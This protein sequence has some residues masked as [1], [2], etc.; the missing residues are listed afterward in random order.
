[1]AEQNHRIRR[2]KQY[3]LQEG[4]KLQSF[5]LEKS[6][7]IE[8]DKVEIEYTQADVVRGNHIKIGPFTI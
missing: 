8:G 5:S 2:R 3:Q 7:V 1:M 4:A 6:E